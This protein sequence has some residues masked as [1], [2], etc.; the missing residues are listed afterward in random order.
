MYG[1]SFTKQK[2]NDTQRAASRIYSVDAN[3]SHLHL[4]LG[5]LLYLISGIKRLSVVGVNT[6]GSGLKVVLHEMILNS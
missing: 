6:K 3:K 4:S 5:F 2:S 1:R